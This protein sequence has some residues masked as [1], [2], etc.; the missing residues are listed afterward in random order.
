MSTRFLS[1]SDLVVCRLRS[2]IWEGYDYDYHEYLRFRPV[3]EVNYGQIMAMRPG[4]A[5]IG[6]AF[7]DSWTVVDSLPHERVI[8]RHFKLAAKSMGSPEW[9]E[10]ILVRTRRGVK[11]IH[12]CYDYCYKR[13]S[14]EEVISVIL[15]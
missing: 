11:I 12:Y 15:E 6:C 13:L 10:D 4:Q 2:M 5:M 1:V 8:L 14:K 9:R 3:K 7:G